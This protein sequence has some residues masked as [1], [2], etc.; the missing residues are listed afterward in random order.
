MPESYSSDSDIV[1]LLRLNCRIGTLEAL[2]RRMTGGCVPT[3]I[4]RRI[5]WQ[6]AVTCAMADVTSTSGWKKILTTATPFRVCDSMFL[7]LLTANDVEYSLKVVICC[8]I[9]SVERPLYVQTTLMTGMSIF[10]KM[11]VGVVLADSTPRMTITSAIT[12]NVYGR[13]R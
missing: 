2:Y 13:R 7:M 5:A 1:S 4:R 10:G 11:S 9:C 8:S 6:T 12:T 3:G